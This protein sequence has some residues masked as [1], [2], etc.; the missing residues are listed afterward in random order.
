MSL[1]GLYSDHSPQTLGFIR[2][3]GLL[4]DDG[5]ADDGHTFYNPFTEHS[6]GATPKAE[7]GKRPG[8]VAWSREQAG[9][10]IERQL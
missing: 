8:G 2:E 5:D 10:C 1:Y 3:F 6:L 4:Q 7:R 9:L